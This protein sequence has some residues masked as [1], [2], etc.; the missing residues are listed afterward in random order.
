MDDFASGDKLR[1]EAATAMGL[2]YSLVTPLTG[3]VVLENQQQYRDAGLEPVPP[4]S[5]PTVPEPEIW[6]MIIIALFLIVW[7]GVRPRLCRAGC[8]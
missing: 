3:A 5:V 2:R 8:R 4:G 1:I 6:A 7:V